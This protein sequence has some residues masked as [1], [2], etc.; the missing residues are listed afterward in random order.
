MKR[1]V[2]ALVFATACSAAR[3]D[4]ETLTESI[5]VYNEGIRWQR[6]A[7]AATA[8]PPKQR[9]KFVDE[10]DERAND[11]KITDFEVVKVDGAGTKAAKV[12]VKV[13][14][15][16]DSEGLLKET[17]AIQSWERHGKDWWMVD[18]VRLRGAE[19]PGLTDRSVEAAGEVSADTVSAGPDAPETVAKP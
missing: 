4:T 10:M 17:H 8:I 13:S 6:Y 14:W 3:K 5:R 7:V 15:Y 2:M 19:M 11:L 9:A 18:A 1:I 12:Q 16:L